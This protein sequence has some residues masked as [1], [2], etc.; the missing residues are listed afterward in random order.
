MNEYYFVSARENNPDYYEEKRL[1]HTHL[2]AKKGKSYIIRLFAHNNNRFGTDAT[3]EDVRVRFHIGPAV[4][5]TAD[6]VHDV[7]GFSSENG[8]WAV[9]VTGYIS[10]S[11]ADPKE[12]RYTMKFVS[13]KPFHLEYIPG[14]ALFENNGIGAGGIRLPDSIVTDE[15][16]MIGFDALDGEIPGCY[17]YSSYSI[18]RVYPVFE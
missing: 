4:H 16:V 5:V 8:Y 2:E 14:S 1:W 9:G 18:I 3:A 6:E 15:G 11:N 7:E 12:Y 13:N 10:S 17:K